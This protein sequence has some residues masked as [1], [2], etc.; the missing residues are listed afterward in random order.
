MQANELQIGGKYNWRNQPERLAYMGRTRYPGDPRTW[1]QFEKIDNPGV[2]WSEVLE[3]DLAHFEQTK[4]PA[5][6]TQP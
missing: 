3:S 5:A 6:D 4:S 1:Y 2:V